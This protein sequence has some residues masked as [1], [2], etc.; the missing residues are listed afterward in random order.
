M[1]GTQ[2]HLEF[3]PE[4]TTDF[5][6]A[7]FA[8]ECLVFAAALILGFTFP[9]RAYGMIGGRGADALRACSRLGDALVRSLHAFVNMAWSVH[10]AGCHAAFALHQLRR[11]GD[12]HAGLGPLIPDVDAG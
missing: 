6:F 11:H 5:R 4:R 2:T 12:G 3:I 1:K 8:E 7:A 9:I 10:P